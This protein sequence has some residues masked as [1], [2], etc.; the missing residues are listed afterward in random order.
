VPLSGKLECFLQKD[1][2]ANAS[3]TVAY[4]NGIIFG[5][6]DTKLVGF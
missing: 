4:P 2:L 1:A 3:K 5:E 6:I